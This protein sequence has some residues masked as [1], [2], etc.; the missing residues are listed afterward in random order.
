MSL[1]V[2]HVTLMLFGSRARLERTEVA[3]LAGTR[4]L[5]SRIQTIFAGLE[6][7]DHEATHDADMDCNDRETGQVPR[8]GASGI[9]GSQLS[10]IGRLLRPPLR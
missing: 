3:A 7:A 5:L 4:I 1:E 9:E 2:L 6:L 10:S 8:P